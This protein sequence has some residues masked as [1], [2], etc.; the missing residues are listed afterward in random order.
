MSDSSIDRAG[1][2]AI[3][4]RRRGAK[5]RDKKGPAALEKV[6]DLP[7]F[8]SITEDLCGIAPLGESFQLRVAVKR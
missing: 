7:E 1:K 5:I 8:L 2:S 3:T 6:T 4:Q